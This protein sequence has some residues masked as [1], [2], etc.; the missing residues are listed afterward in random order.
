MLYFFG[1]L[2]ELCLCSWTPRRRCSTT[3]PCLPAAPFASALRT[4]STPI[5]AL[6][7]ASVYAVS[8]RAM[9]WSDLPPKCGGVGGGESSEG[10]VGVQTEGAFQGQR[11]KATTVLTTVSSYF[12]VCSPRSTPRSTWPSSARNSLLGRRSSA[13]SRW[14]RFSARAASAPSTPASGCGTAATWPS[15]TWPGPR[16]PTGTW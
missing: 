14:A 16:L 1:C 13:P 10:K 4:P 3:T 7:Q 15:S 5:S 12:Q 8:T 2:C 9:F 11:T 6:Q